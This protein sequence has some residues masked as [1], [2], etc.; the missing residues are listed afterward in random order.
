MQNGIIVYLG[1]FELPDKNAAAHRVLSNAKALRDL[2]YTVVFLD[3][4]KKLSWENNILNTKREVQGFTCYSRPYPK[5]KTEWLSYLTDISLFQ[6]VIAQYSNIQ[7]IICYNYQAVALQKLLTCCHKQNIKVVSDC[8]EWYSADKS[9]FVFFVL[10]SFD[11][12][13]RMRIVHKRLNGLI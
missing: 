4:D 12:W 13:Y 3:V 11:T 7:A 9:N 1:G 5:S 2:G 8:T 10:K 6:Q